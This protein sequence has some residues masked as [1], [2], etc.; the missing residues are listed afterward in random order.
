[1]LP[2]AYTR[3][4]E[5]EERGGEKNRAD[6]FLKVGGQQGGK[7]EKKKRE[8]R[9]MPIRECRN[10]AGEREK[11]RKEKGKNLGLRRSFAAEGG[12]KKK[13]SVGFSSPTP[14]QSA[15]RK[16]ERKGGKP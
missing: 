16:K 15:A 14:L 13:G 10:G 3:R 5:E 12:K 7:P 9:S 4:G 2:G 6:F 1:L 8:T 11:E